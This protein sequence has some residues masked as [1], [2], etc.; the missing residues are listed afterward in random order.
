MNKR[1]SET[2]N[3]CRVAGDDVQPET[4]R[5]DYQVCVGD[6]GRAGATQHFADAAT[7]D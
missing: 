2:F 7:I 6:V 3:V 4:G 1:A 5:C